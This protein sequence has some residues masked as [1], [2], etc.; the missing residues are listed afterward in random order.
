MQ[1]NAGLWAG[2][3]LLGALAALFG[4]MAFNANNEVARLKSSLTNSS[5]STLAREH[6]NQDV[7]KLLSD[8]LKSEG[9]IKQLNATLVDKDREILRVRGEVEAEVNNAKLLQNR[10]QAAESDRRVQAAAFKNLRDEFAALGASL[11]QSKQNQIDELKGWNAQAQADN[12]RLEREARTLTEQNAERDT[13]AR[14]QAA[15]AA[16]R[17]ARLEQTLARY[18]NTGAQGVAA[19]ANPKEFDGEVLEVDLA[20]QVVIVNVGKYNRARAGMRFDVRRQRGPEWVVIA[21]IELTRVE[22]TYS[23]A[24]ILG[25]VAPIK[26]C[27][28]S[29]DNPNKNGCGWTT[30]DMFMRYCPFCTMIEKDGKKTDMVL[31]LEVLRHEERSTMD[32]MNPILKGDKI[33][34]PMFDPD[35][36]TRFV[37]I[38]DPIINSRDQIVEMIRNYNGELLEQ[39]TPE[40]D[41]VIVGRTFGRVEGQS[42]EMAKRA[43][44]HAAMIEEARAFGI[45]FLRESELLQFL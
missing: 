15:E 12:A 28:R 33:F 17:A 19:V 18:T 23:E 16:A 22:E 21:Q 1:Q 20:R 34:N 3:V 43:E 10:L 32:P 36:R 42:A 24:L 38:G 30:E 39:I 6:Q 5:A 37:L 44:T 2:V 29:E 26:Y 27:P 7:G 31:E 41:Y 25:S 45:K 4:V 8:L 13:R 40:I 14:K 9:E 35:H 11:D